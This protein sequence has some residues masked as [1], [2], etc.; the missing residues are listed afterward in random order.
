MPLRR[1]RRP[2]HRQASSERGC[3]LLIASIP[4]A[5]VLSES[6]AGWEMLK[7]LLSELKPFC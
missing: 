6:R 4:A 3:V 7:T 5:E 1:R 2:N